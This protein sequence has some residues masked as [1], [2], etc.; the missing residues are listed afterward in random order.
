M[1]RIKTIL[2]S[3]HLPSLREGSGVG[4]ILPSLWEGLGV[5]LI[6]FTSCVR[7]PELHLYDSVETDFD[8]PIVDLDLDVIWDYEIGYNI[9]YDWKAEWSYGWDMQD[10]EIFG[11]IGY[12]EPTVF[13][14]RRYYTGETPRVPHTQVIGSTMYQ[15]HF[16]GRF[17]WGYWDLLIWNEVH[18]LD[19][20]QSI[21]FDEATSLDAVTAYTNPSM[22]PARYNAPKFT[23]AFWAPE[24]LFAA[25]DRAIE[26]NKSLEGFEYDKERD[27]YIKKLNM[28]MQPITYI[29][30]TQVILHN[31]KGRITSVDGNADLSGMARTTTLNTGVAGEDAITI[32]FNTRMKKD[33]PL[34]P[35][36]P[37][38]AADPGATA[39][40]TAERVDIIG[41]RLLTFGICNHAGNRVSRAEELTDKYKHYLD[42]T[43]QFN[44][45]MDSTFVFDVTKQVRERYKGGVITVE[46]DV[47]TVPIP[48]RSGGSGFNAIVKET[49]DGGTWEFEM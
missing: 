34:I 22:H 25:Y 24:A 41:G 2:K 23:N 33:M 36:K 49:E 18:T 42:V 28:T 11:E 17:D 13:N 46:L 12:T 39:P 10:K 37:E 43:M 31:N 40:V 5:G 20:V 26:I 9:T 38:T 7:L 44:N 19:G 47:D 27:I 30:L 21:H 35:Y 4:F 8:I 6:L 32:Y 48:R 3:I 16:Q 15:P 45:G 14:L 29:Y 1:R